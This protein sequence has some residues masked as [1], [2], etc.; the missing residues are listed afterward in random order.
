MKVYAV[1]WN[2]DL[3]DLGEWAL[4]R[5][6]YTSE[7]DAMKRAERIE[8][9]GDAEIRLYA[10]VEELELVDSGAYTT[11]ER[12]DRACAER[13]QWRELCGQMLDAAHEIRRIADAHMPEG[14]RELTKADDA[15]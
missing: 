1:G 4:D 11:R 15:R 5:R 14:A 9:A 7:A 3:D 10:H 6:C 2:D 12:Y 13:D 8:G